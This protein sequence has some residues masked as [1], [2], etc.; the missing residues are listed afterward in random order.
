MSI[1]FWRPLPLAGQ[2][3]ADG[4]T[5]VSGAVHVH[6]THSD[7]S[8]TPAE[9]LAAA[10]E[11]DLDFLVI[12]DHNNLD[13]KDVEGYHGRLL[14]I[15]GSELSTGAGHVLALGIPD[16]AFRF[17]GDALEVL[18]DV[19]ELRGYA[20]AAHPSSPRA[21]FQW[22][23]WRLPG[24]WGLELINGDSQWRAAGAWALARTAALYALNPD[25]ALL[26]SLTPPSATLQRWDALLTERD[27]PGLAGADAHG[28]LRVGKDRT[29]PFPSDAALLGLVRNHV[30]LDAPLT[31]NAAAD[32]AAIAR[33]LGGGRSYLGL[34]ALAPA[35]GFYFRAEDGEGRWGMG[36]TV[37]PSPSL[38]LRSG[39][40]LPRGARVLLLRD[41][42][43]AGEG[44]AGLD[45]KAPGPGVYRV[46]VRVPGWEF[47]W[48]VSN[49]IYVFEPARAE[50]RA[51]RA[52]WPES[53]PAPRPARM[54]DGF[55]GT[56]VFASEFDPSSSMNREVLVPGAGIDGRGSA[57]LEFRLGAP[58]PGRPHT[59]CA[60]VSR[61]P[62]DLSGTQGL[63][64]ALRADGVYRIWVQLR[65][66]NPA[67]ADEGLEHWFTSVRAEPAWRR[68]AVPYTRFRSFN[69][70]S[71]GRLD[72]DRV[73]QVVFVLDRGAVKPGTSGTIWIDELGVYD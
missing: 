70:R 2:A 31:G 12:T 47:P 11:A 14:A 17:S 69:P 65:D 20:F 29:L 8:H 5:R 33:A 32:A 54:V 49:P 37:A 64:F 62:R 55:E 19:R 41:G 44:E 23:G 48:I 18:D 25:Y 26:G 38:R 34:D 46:E 61:E 7:G 30:F 66:T 35:G 56:T 13:A 21:D 58:G 22:T 50:E 68:V 16:P 43:P 1:V 63:V 53:P 52:A 36:E 73:Q 71:D 10:R 3:P 60:L 72:L 4:L 27:V 28:G 42:R 67:S 45:V 59:W 9:V 24:P 40:A 51:R 15:V 6:T 39:G 57:R